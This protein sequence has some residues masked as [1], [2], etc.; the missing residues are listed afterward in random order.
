MS[1]LVR[2]CTF[3]YFSC[4]VYPLWQMDCP[5]EWKMSGKLKQTRLVTHVHSDSKINDGRPFSHNQCCESQ[6]I[7]LVNS[8]KK[9]V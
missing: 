3:P 6:C 5:Y 8:E 2:L 9:I 4:I 7:V 1:V